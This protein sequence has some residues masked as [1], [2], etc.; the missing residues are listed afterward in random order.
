MKPPLVFV[1]CLLVPVLGHAEPIESFKFGWAPFYSPN[2]TVDDPD[3]STDSSQ[4]FL[5]L[6]AV[7]LYPF[8]RDNR[9][10]ANITKY[11]FTL[12]A[13]QNDI[14]QDVKSLTV[15]G[16]Y[17][18]RLRL[19]RYFKPWIGIGPQIEF[20]DR[21]GRHIVDADGFLAQTFSDQD[22]LAYALGVVASH[23]WPLTDHIEFGV[24]AQY[25]FSISD[26]IEGGALG[27]LFLYRLE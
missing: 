6:S 27:G 1:F 16:F 4:E 8:G 18:R 21:T 24:N 15:A 19:S 12:D 3:G 25:L 20:S 17:Q 2:L 22:G 26:A 13:S 23:E 5:A 9:W 7:A 11:D 10:M 14:G